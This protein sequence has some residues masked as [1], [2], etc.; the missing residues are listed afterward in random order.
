MALYLSLHTNIHVG[1]LVLLNCYST[2]LSAQLGAGLSI[3]KMIAAVVIIAFGM[4]YY[5]NGKVL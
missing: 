1:M 5:H 4:W 3:V 2:K